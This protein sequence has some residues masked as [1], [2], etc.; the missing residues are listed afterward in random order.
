MNTAK[1]HSCATLSPAGLPE[2]GARLTW[3]TE[4]TRYYENKRYREL[5]AKT[6]C[7]FTEIEEIMKQN[8]GIRTL[9][10]PVYRRE[11]YLRASEVFAKREA[12]ERQRIERFGE[13]RPIMTAEAFGNRI[14]SVQGRIYSSD[15]KSFPQF[16][17]DFLVSRF[18][19]EWTEEQDRLDPSKWHPI[20]SW[21]V[22]G[23]SHHLK[24]LEGKPAGHRVEPSGFL[25]AYLGFAY[26]LYVVDDNNDLDERLLKRLRNREQFQGAR[27]ELFAE[28]TCLRAGFTIVH[29]DDTAPGRHVEF[30]ATHKKSG[31]RLAVEAKS[32]QRPGVIAHPGVPAPAERPDYGFSRLL[33]DAV[34]KQS[35]LPLVVFMDTNLDPSGAESFF[36][37]P[38]PVPEPTL[39]VISIIDTARKQ[40]GGRDPYNLL[41]FTNIPHHYG[42]DDDGIDDLPRNWIA[43]IAETPNIAFGDPAL[44]RELAIASELYGKIPNEFPEPLS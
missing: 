33:K 13:I 30:T 7:P 5:E 3:E 17:N 20:T 36:G 6:T 40:N 12:D 37:L 31:L 4:S 10:D 22:R 25:A 41:V 11:L 19:S 1:V 28:A 2:Q 34:T 35:S 26:D 9:S 23:L 8:H 42:G 15:W 43:Y 14:V 32:R 27:H 18:G 21:R 39:E 44:L 29:E 38:A 16:L 24:T